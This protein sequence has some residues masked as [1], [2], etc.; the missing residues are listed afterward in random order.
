MDV[1]E[2]VKQRISTR[3]FRDTPIPES[4]IRAWLEAAQRAPSGGNLQPWRVIVLAVRGPQ[5]QPT[6]RAC[7]V[8]ATRP[9][10]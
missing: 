9:R 2:A 6:A 7:G 5:R 10:V 8:T 1:T 4:D 3:A